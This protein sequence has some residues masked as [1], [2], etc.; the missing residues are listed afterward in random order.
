MLPE[1]NGRKLEWLQI[2][3]TSKITVSLHGTYAWIHYT[4]NQDLSLMNMN[5]WYFPPS[6]FAHHVWMN[7]SFLSD[8]TSHTENLLLRTIKKMIILLVHPS[9]SST[10]FSFPAA[11]QT[12]EPYEGKRKHSWFLYRKRKNFHLMFRV[13]QSRSTFLLLFCIGNNVMF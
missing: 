6:Y 2:Q 11:F 13:A 9:C 7:D 8:R 12:S 5:H 4:D 1:I 3:N 10:C